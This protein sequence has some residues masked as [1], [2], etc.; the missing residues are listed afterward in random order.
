MT[1]DRL[2]SATC[3]AVLILRHLRHGCPSASLRTR[4]RA[5]TKIRRSH[6]ESEGPTLLEDD[7]R[8]PHRSRVVED[9]SISDSGLGEWGVGL[10]GIF[11]F[12]WIT[13]VDFSW[14]VA[15]SSSLKPASSVFSSSAI[16]ERSWQA[17]AVSPEPSADSRVTFAI[18]STLLLICYVAA[19]CSV[20]AAAI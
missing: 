8:G 16:F 4:S 18:W 11:L 10:A 13:A 19:D 5:L 7:A 15:D 14:M 6:A 1:A 20:A 12:D 3:K 17:L 9:I 2:F